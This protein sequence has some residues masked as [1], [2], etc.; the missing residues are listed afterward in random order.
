MKN[1]K[2]VHFQESCF[3]IPIGASGSLAV[4]TALYLSHRRKSSKSE[5]HFWATYRKYL[6]SKGVAC[7]VDQQ[8]P[9]QVP[10]EDSQVFD[11]HL[12]LTKKKLPRH[13]SSN[14]AAGITDARCT[15]APGPKNQA[16]HRHNSCGWL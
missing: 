6:K 5:S 4:P 2:N 12:P 8:G 10:V 13:P 11:I 14:S 3:S 15:R 9:I 7:V 16:R 1:E